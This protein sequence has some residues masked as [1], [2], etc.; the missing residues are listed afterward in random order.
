MSQRI[1]CNKDLCQLTLSAEMS[2]D[3][4][5]DMLTDMSAKSRLTCRLTLG[6]HVDHSRSTCRPTLGPTPSD[7]SPP[8]G[9][10]YAHFVSS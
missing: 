4:L 9:Q 7:T 3:M 10:H 6:Q 1:M 5:T 2:A 8:L